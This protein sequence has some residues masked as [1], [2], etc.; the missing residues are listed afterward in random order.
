LFFEL[1]FNHKSESF[2][3]KKQLKQKKVESMTGVLADVIL[4]GDAAL[5]TKL[6]ETNIETE[7][8]HQLVCDS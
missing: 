2:I 5:D 1:K 4:K 7:C 3:S 8:Y 6:S